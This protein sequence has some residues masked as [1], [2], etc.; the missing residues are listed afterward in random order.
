MFS[1]VVGLLEVVGLAV[2]DERRC[3]G[4][5]LQMTGA[6]TLKLRLWSSVVVLGMARSSRSAERRTE[7]GSAREIRRR[8]Q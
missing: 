3:S 2:K 4:R 8:H 6:A 1:E 5:L 7:T